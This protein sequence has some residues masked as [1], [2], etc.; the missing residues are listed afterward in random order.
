MLFCV[1]PTRSIFAGAASPEPADTVSPTTGRS[2]SKF[3][4]PGDPF[5]ELAHTSPGAV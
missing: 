1:V 2:W 5:L 3:L 4:M